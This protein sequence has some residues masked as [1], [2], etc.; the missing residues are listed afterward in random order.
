MLYDGKLVLG[1]EIARQ[2]H[3]VTPRFH[4]LVIIRSADPAEQLRKY[5]RSPGVDVVMSKHSG[6]VRRAED[7]R[8]QGAEGGVGAG[9][10]G[11]GAGR[12][13]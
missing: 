5:R 6:Q 7:A 10:G 8:A 12:G 13:G 1:T 2:L 3:A 4:G 9:A 11:E